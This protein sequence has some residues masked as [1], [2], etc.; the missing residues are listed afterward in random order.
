MTTVFW[1]A[2]RR[3]RSHMYSNTSQTCCLAT[4]PIYIQSVTRHKSGSNLIGKDGISLFTQPSK[5]L[6]CQEIKKKKW[7]ESLQ[8]VDVNLVEVKPFGESDHSVGL[9]GKRSIRAERPM[10]GDES[11][12]T[13][14][15][16]RS[17]CATSFK[18]R[19]KTKCLRRD[20]KRG[21]RYKILIGWCNRG[22]PRV[23]TG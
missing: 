21:R 20:D 5:K 14:N 19:M 16:L 18:R 2:C 11:Q 4:Y 8:L 22:Q 1:T 6:T 3:Q 9:L 17:T 23:K 13:S 7:F 10:K 15:K 12:L